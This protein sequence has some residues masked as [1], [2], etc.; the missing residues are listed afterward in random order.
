MIPPGVKQ[1]VSSAL[2]VKLYCFSILSGNP[3]SSHTPI[4]QI[5]VESQRSGV[6]L[7]LTEQYLLFLLTQSR[8]SCDQIPKKWP[9][10]NAIDPAG[11]TAG[12]N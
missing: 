7:G 4:P 3:K 11:S 10:A 9:P 6:L 1:Q 8:C 2:T 12:Y 5:A